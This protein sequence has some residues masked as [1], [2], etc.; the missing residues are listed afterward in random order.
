MTSPLGS[1][2]T[3]IETLNHADLRTPPRRI[4]DIFDMRSLVVAASFVTT[5]VFCVK[6][7][8]VIAALHLILFG[9]S[10]ER[11]PMSIKYLNEV[12]DS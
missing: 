4:S 7:A 6:I 10:I 9:N 12:Y 5:Q 3:G 8:Q 1:F 11:K 2:K